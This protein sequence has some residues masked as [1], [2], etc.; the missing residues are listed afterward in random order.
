MLRSVYTSNFSFYISLMAIF[1]SIKFISFI[2][3][4]FQ[5]LIIE[6]INTNEKVTFKSINKTN[7]IID[8]KY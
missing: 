2:F 4:I 3:I 1:I 7:I 8:T 6:K 5:K